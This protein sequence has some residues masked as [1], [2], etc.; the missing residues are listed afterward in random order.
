MDGVVRCGLF[1]GVSDWAHEL[2]YGLVNGL[3]LPCTLAG[4]SVVAML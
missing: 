1:T 3:H 2:G 4:P